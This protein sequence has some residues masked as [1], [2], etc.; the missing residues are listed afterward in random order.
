[1]YQCA[2]QAVVQCTKGTVIFQSDRVSPSAYAATERAFHQLL[3]R[4]ASVDM[5]AAKGK[6]VVTI[7]LSTTTLSHEIANQT[8]KDQERL[9]MAERHK[10]LREDQVVLAALMPSLAV[11]CI[12][13][14][15]VEEAHNVDAF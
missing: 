14:D 2:V 5:E 13:Q 15:A 7:L 8:A 10:E 9:D 6:T 3:R 4:I 11:Q 1:M 12:P